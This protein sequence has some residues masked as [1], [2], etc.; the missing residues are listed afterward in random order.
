MT[1]RLSPPESIWSEPTATIAVVDLE[2]ACALYGLDSLPFPLGRSRPVGSVWL[3]T[4][5]VRPIDERLNDDLLGVRAWVET[6]VRSDVCVECRVRYSVED[7]PDLRLHGLRS[8][9]SAFVAVQGSDCGV[10]LVDIYSVSPE[11]MGPAIV[12]SVGLVGAG[13][14]PR[15][16]VATSGEPSPAASPESDLDFLAP[17]PSDAT[18]ARRGVRDVV[19]TGTLQVRSN[20]ALSILRWVQIRDDGDYVFD[21]GDAENAEPVDV[22]T[23]TTYL[24]GMIADVTRWLT[25]DC[26]GVAGLVRRVARRGIPGAANRTAPIRAVRRCYR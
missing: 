9:E 25:T 19:A 20:P 13:A 21:S 8:G 12:E 24:N 11:M 6:L 5:N 2:A 15:I 1:T 23:L 18:A 10:D 14:H 7:T 4:R 26:R 3:A 16:N 22:E 17:P